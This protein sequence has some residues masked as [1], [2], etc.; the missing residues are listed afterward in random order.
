MELN[1]YQEKA[2]STCMNS[3]NN[4]S[5]MLLNLVSEVGEFSGKL[6]KAIRKKQVAIG[7]QTSINRNKLTVIDDDFD[8]LTFDQE[9]RKEAGDILWQFAGLIHVMG[10]KLNDVG[11]ENLIKLADRK[12]RGVIDGDG[13]NR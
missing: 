8:V 13:D 12:E 1:K 2:M 11:Y 10:W 4:I 9:L 7:G 5:Y 3:C 6:A